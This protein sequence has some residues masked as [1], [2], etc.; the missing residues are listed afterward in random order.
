VS[1]HEEN[2]S[3]HKPT[4]NG[5]RIKGFAIVNHHTDGMEKNALFKIAPD[6]E[7]QHCSFNHFHINSQARL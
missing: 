3:H 5:N 1:H 7:K 2:P 6:H 4:G